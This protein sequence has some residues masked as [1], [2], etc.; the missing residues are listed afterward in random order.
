MF[1]GVLKRMVDTVARLA[2][3]FMVLGGSAQAAQV[4][5]HFWPTP[6]TLEN[7]EESGFLYTWPEYRVLLQE[8]NAQGTYTPAAISD[9]L[10][11]ELSR[12]FK[13][14]SGSVIQI[15][16]DATAKT[17]GLEIPGGH[18]LRSEN[19]QLLQPIAQDFVSCL[20][21][22]TPDE[23]T[24]MKLVLMQPGTF[25]TTLD[26]GKMD[27]AAKMFENYKANRCQNGTTTVPNLTK[28]EVEM[29][30]TVLLTGATD[31][32][33]TDGDLLVLTRLY[34]DLLFATQ[35]LWVR[36]T[37]ATLKAHI[38]GAMGGFPVPLRQDWL[39]SDYSSFVDFVLLT[40]DTSGLSKAQYLD[41]ASLCGMNSVSQIFSTFALKQCS[42]QGRVSMIHVVLGASRAVYFVKGGQ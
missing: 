5:W 25:V 34:H 33:V 7:P 20:S 23:L 2:L 30:L 13:P 11:G 18:A 35:G 16:R 4:D 14:A 26:Q 37:L 31:A 22:L 24:E 27:I 41:L 1:A 8:K 3:S 38:A 21:T 17:W 28:S 9:A 6:V 29:Y 10:A 12:L 40:R 36:V 19:S 42:T 39:N 15:A 32:R